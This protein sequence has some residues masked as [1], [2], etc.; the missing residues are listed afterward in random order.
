MRICLGARAFCGAGL[1][2]PK[3]L[4][5][6]GPV[7]S[8]ARVAS[9]SRGAGF[10]LR[11][12]SFLRAEKG[13]KDALRGRGHG[14]RALR[15]AAGGSPHAP[16]PLRTP[17]DG[18]RG[19]RNGSPAVTTGARGSNGARSLS[20][21]TGACPGKCRDHLPPRGAPALAHTAGHG[22]KRRADDIRPY[23]GGVPSRWAVR[24]VQGPMSRPAI[25]PKNLL[26][27]GGSTAK[28]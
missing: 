16:L 14:D 7:S 10:R 4:V 20:R 21:P 22:G 24:P 25:P 1:I 18:G 8:P 13:G 11:A 6:Q 5:W 26:K 2:R 3:S 17:I 19:T 23:K 28:P 27:K 12:T 15:C 9:L